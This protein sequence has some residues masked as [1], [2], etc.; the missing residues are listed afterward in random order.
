LHSVHGYYFE[1]QS[2]IGQK[3]IRGFAY[4]QAKWLRLFLLSTHDQQPVHHLTI[5]IVIERETHH[6]FILRSRCLG[7]LRPDHSTES[8]A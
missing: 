8:Y 4:Q 5:A 2:V 6:T 1:V 3:S 7:R